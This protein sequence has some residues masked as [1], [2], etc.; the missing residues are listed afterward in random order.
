MIW[1]C[2]IWVESCGCI[3]L[4]VM[5]CLSSGL[6]ILRVSI[7]MANVARVDHLR[8]SFFVVNQI[9]SLIICL[10]LTDFLCDKDNQIKL[11]QLRQCLELYLFS[12][13]QVALRA[14]TVGD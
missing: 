7:S 14:Y 4:Q 12:P 9:V 1:S 13:S 5:D 10:L 8:G 11:C 3:L 2:D 6:L